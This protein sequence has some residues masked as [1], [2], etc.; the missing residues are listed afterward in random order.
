MALDAEVPQR[1][2]VIT[3]AFVV[4]EPA[5]LL[6]RLAALAT[7]ALLALR[8]GRQTSQRR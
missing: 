6:S 7:L 5:A 2:V 3:R 8:R 4:P 1:L